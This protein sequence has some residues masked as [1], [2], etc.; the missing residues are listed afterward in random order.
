MSPSKLILSANALFWVTRSDSF[1]DGLVVKAFAR[2]SLD[3]TEAGMLNRIRRNAGDSPLGRFV[4]KSGVHHLLVD[5]QQFETDAGPGEHK[6]QRPKP[7]GCRRDVGRNLRGMS[8]L[9]TSPTRRSPSGA[10]FSQGQISVDAANKRHQ[11]YFAAR[12]LFATATAEDLAGPRVKYMI[13]LQ[14]I[15]SSG[16]G[17]SARRDSNDDRIGNVAK[18]VADANERISADSICAYARC[19]D[20]P[21]YWRVFPPVQ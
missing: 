3:P 10:R 1:C 7:P 5:R 19:F 12:Q 4:R 11:V 6:E 21:R 18:E 17:V 9:S 14:R 15:R 20:S 2:P 13:V 8:W 16:G